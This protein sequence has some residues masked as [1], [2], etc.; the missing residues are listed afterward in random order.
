MTKEAH[1][2]GL[3]MLP[4]YVEMSEGQL[5]ASQEQLKNLRM[6][7]SKPHILDEATVNR[8]IKLHRSQ[9]ADNWVFFEQCKKWRNDNPSEEQLRLIAQIE[10][11]AAQLEMVNLEILALAESFKGKTIESIMGKD[12][13]ELG[14]DWL[15]K[16]F[17]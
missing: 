6:A 13:F 4:L 11:S 15:L 17:S 14:F 5:E 16:K 3:N 8:V 12:D 1:F 10:K 9:N 2:Y 7:K